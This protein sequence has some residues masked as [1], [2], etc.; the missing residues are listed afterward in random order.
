MKTMLMVLWTPIIGA[1]W[2][3]WSVLY[4]EHVIEKAR[5]DK[6]KA[7]WLYLNARGDSDET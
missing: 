7:Y 4:D 1:V 6:E 2:L 3:I 5:K